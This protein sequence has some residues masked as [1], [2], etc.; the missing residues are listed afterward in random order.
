MM[1]DNVDSDACVGSK[2]RMTEIEESLLQQLQEPS[3]SISTQEQEVSKESSFTTSSAQE[4]QEIVQDIPSPSSSKK[5][6]CSFIE[7]HGS[8][9]I[10]ENKGMLGCVGEDKVI[11]SDLVSWSFGCEGNSED[12][13]RPVEMGV[14]VQETKNCIVGSVFGGEKSQG[15]I[16]GTINDVKTEKEEQLDSAKSEVGYLG[17]EE[18]DKHG[19]SDT[20]DLNGIE[21]EMG[22][23]IV[24]KKEHFVKE[25]TEA[26]TLLEAKKK[27]LLAKLDA[28]SIFED[29]IHMEKVSAFDITAGILGGLKGIDESVRPSLKV[30]VIDDIALIETVP[31]P[32]TGNVGLK[33]AERNVKKNEKQE[34][35]RKKAKRPR[36]KGKDGKKILE[37]S[38]EQNKM[39]QVRKAISIKNGEAQNGGQKNGDQIRKYSREEM[40]A[41]RFVNIVDQRKLWRAIH[42]GLGDAVVK[43]YNDLAGLKR[44]KNICINFDPRQI[45]GRKEDV[46]GILENTEDKAEHLNLLGPSRQSFGGE[47]ICTF[48]EEEYDEDE[49]SDEDYASIH[50]PAFLVEGEPDFESGPPEDGL[51]YLRRVRWEAAHI[52]KVKVA[53]LDKSKVH[54][55]QSVYM[56]QIPEIAKCPENLIPLKQWEDA[57]LAD[58]SVLRMFL[59]RNESSSTEIS[60]KLQYMAVDHEQNTS[61]PQPAECIILQ[62][63]SHRS[64]ISDSSCNYPTLSAILAMDSVARVSALKKRIN[65]AETMST[66]S[67]HDCVWLFA[68]CAAVDTPLDADTSAAL[69][70]LL[71]KCASLRAAKSEL[72][73]EVIMLNI[74]ATISGRYFGQ[75]ES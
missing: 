54:N 18:F 21:V 49:D 46:P 65:L 32:K 7:P 35:D 30:E 66:L 73:D 6:K 13:A 70:S 33:I 56:L 19:A 58:F 43:E 60:C 45:F 37:T 68:L 15:E 62:N 38:N 51:E 71:R 67:K 41:L 74:L 69:R 42:T 10:E 11:P 17:A 9:I 26:Q 75:S 22:S 14:Q 2:R 25:K 28:G 50:R 24:E 34:A 1:A 59:S 23:V 3:T 48:L 20:G 44:Q 8:S 64:S 55:E 5:V 61:S 4:H 57:F 27:Q 47:D 63:M 16:E 12:I 31:V 40:E 29:K 72:D 36:R 39:I 53:K 52:P